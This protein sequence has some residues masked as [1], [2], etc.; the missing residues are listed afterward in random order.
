MPRPL[1]SLRPSPTIRYSVP[2]GRRCH[3]RTPAARRR[4]AAPRCATHPRATVDVPGLLHAAVERIRRRRRPW[5]ATE[6]PP[7]GLRPEPRHLLGEIARKEHDVPTGLGRGHADRE[8]VD[9]EIQV[10]AQCPAP[11]HRL[12]I[13]IVAAIIEALAGCSRVLPSLRTPESLV[14]AEQR[15]RS[16]AYSRLPPR[17][18]VITAGV[19]CLTTSLSVQDR[20]VAC[21]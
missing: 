15:A 14:V 4:P 21:W 13:A 18:Q 3:S 7:S 6:G 8:D 9:A 12:W 20:P 19:S 11:H 2:A 1:R 17:D 16:H 10:R 5:R